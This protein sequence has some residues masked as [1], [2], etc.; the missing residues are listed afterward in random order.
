MAQDN[1]MKQI[2]ALII[3]L[4]LALNTNATFTTYL[5]TSTYNSCSI[6]WDEN[7]LTSG[8]NYVLDRNIVGIG[9][10]DLNFLATNSG[11]IDGDGIE[12]IVFAR[13]YSTWATSGQT[14]SRLNWIRN[15]GTNQNPI[16][17]WQNKIDISGTD[18]IHVNADL[19]IRQQYRPAVCD[20]DNDG[21]Q[22]LIFWV[23]KAFS[24]WSKV[25]LYKNNGD[26]TFTYQ[27]YLPIGPAKVGCGVLCD[28]AVSEQDSS[29]ACADLDGDNYPEIILG[30]TR[31]ASANANDSAVQGMGV[32]KNNV[33]IISTSS[34]PIQFSYNGPNYPSGDSPYIF[35]GTIDVNNDGIIDVVNGMARN[36]HDEDTDSY[37]YFKN[38]S[39]LGNFS[40][41]SS[42]FTN[43]FTKSVPFKTELY[44]GDI[45]DLNKTMVGQSAYYLPFAVWDSNIAS[46]KIKRDGTQIGTSAYKSYVDSLNLS[47]STSY[48]YSVDAYRGDVLNES[49]TNLA[50]TTG[51]FPF[52][53]ENISNLG[54]YYF[55]SLHLI[56]ADETA[57]LIVKITNVYPSATDLNIFIENSLTDGRQ[58]FVYTGTDGIAWVF[59]D[60]LTNG[61]TDS[62][63]IQKIWDENKNVYQYRFQESFLASETKYYKFTYR[64][65]SRYYSTVAGSSSW[66]NQYEPEQQDINGLMRD[67]WTVTYYSNVFSKNLDAKAIITTGGLVTSAQSYELQFNAYKTTTDVVNVV[68]ERYN[69]HNNA[70]TVISTIPLTTNEHRYSVPITLY[71]INEHVV[72][73]TNAQSFS[74]NVIFSDYALEESNYFRDRMILLK[75]NYEPLDQWIDV[76]SNSHAYIDEGQPFR[77]QTTIYDRDGKILTETI[78]VYAYGT[79]DANRVYQLDYNILTPV[80]ENIRTLSEAINGIVLIK[81]GRITGVSTPIKVTVTICDATQCLAEQSQWLRLHNYPFFPTDFFLQNQEQTRTL[82]VGPKGRF[83]IQSR[84]PNTV[85]ALRVRIYLGQFMCAI[86]QNGQTIDGTPCTGPRVAP[87]GNKVFEKYLYR[88]HDFNCTTQEDCSFDYDFDDEFHYFYEAP[89]TTITNLLFNTTDSNDF[90]ART[91]YNIGKQ[92]LTVWAELQ[93]IPDTQ[94]VDN[95]CFP[96]L[97]GTPLKSR[98]YA[99]VNN[100]RAALEDNPAYVRYMGMCIAVPFFGDICTGSNFLWVYGDHLKFTQ[101]VFNNGGNIPDQWKNSFM[102]K[103]ADS[104]SCEKIG[105]HS[106]A[107]K[108]VAKV[109]TTDLSDIH[110]YTDAYFTLTEINNAGATMRDFKNKF[111]PI[112]T[113]FDNQGDSAVNTFIWN[114][115]LYDENGNSVRDHNRYKINLNFTD[116][117]LRNKDAT[118]TLNFRVDDSNISDTNA[119]FL[120]LNSLKS[121]PN[122][123]SILFQGT[124]LTNGM[125]ID[126]I[127]GTMLTNFSGYDTL[128]SN[129]ENQIGTFTIGIEDIIKLQE[130]T[131]YSMTEDWNNFVSENIGIA[132]GICFSGDDTFWNADSVFDVN[133]TDVSTAIQWLDAQSHRAKTKLYAIQSCGTGQYVSAIHER[134]DLY[135]SLPQINLQLAEAFQKFK[136]QKYRNITM[137]LTGVPNNY[138]ELKVLGGFSDTNTNPQTIINDLAKKGLSPI[139]EPLKLEFVEL[140]KKITIPN[141]LVS[142]GNLVDTIEQRN[143]SLKLTYKTNNFQNKKSTII[144]FATFIPDARGRDWWAGLNTD[145]RSLIVGN[146]I[147]I[148]VIVL[149]I[150]LLSAIARIAPTGR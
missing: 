10:F 150:V 62:N 66:W 30:T 146:L 98:T 16:F 13:I 103:L 52:T 76:N 85:S 83:F 122:N 67:V 124:I 138:E 144:N 108:V 82:N 137:K 143:M 118:A 126:Q 80:E 48:T 60:S 92:P 27:G 86:D 127:E 21:K 113:Y 128:K 125:Q 44:D 136:G 119:Y 90:W 116:N 26:N 109:I 39:T 32:W 7:K 17:N 50:C 55:D 149:I 3:L 40:F 95:N 1:T 147:T 148:F 139:E 79:N 25:G 68:V 58:Y 4:L 117:S 41:V 132:E 130:K 110:Q 18:D 100:L 8:V 142:T 33:G 29:F 99:T 123:N 111:Y 45:I 49:S 61:T 35:V 104:S 87:D 72:I 20:Y 65:P 63:P 71:D 84:L 6:Y 112:Q 75:E 135:T 134:S 42:S 37:Q 19:S 11:D 121:M 89:F 105:A 77:F 133:V 56:P 106:Q 70:E 129:M 47:S 31:F 101:D 114:S 12:D 107:Y 54:S 64:L 102:A 14:N 9:N 73:K 34:Y 78:R 131:N 115:N 93:G 81:E 38:N 57:N 120:P 91:L 94:V 43:Y 69:D 140:G 23:A 46:Y 51:P 59:N 141:Y 22:D 2:I 96:S 145:L 28:D 15:T 5:N 88:N 36:M 53:V 74:S 24:N 97:M